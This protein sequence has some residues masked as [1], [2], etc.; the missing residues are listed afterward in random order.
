MTMGRSG[1]FTLTRS[2]AS[3][4]LIVGLND[5]VGRE[6]VSAMRQGS[7]MMIGDGRRG[8]LFSLR[9]SSDALSQLD[10]HCRMQAFRTAG[11]TA[12]PGSA[13]LPPDPF[14]GRYQRFTDEAT[15]TFPDPGDPFDV[16]RRYNDTDVPGFDL[17]SGLTDPL[18]AGIS[19]RQC[20]ALC[21]LTEDCTIYT[22]NGRDG[23]ICFL[24][25]GANGAT[26]YRGAVSGELTEA[27][28]RLPPPPTRG[29]GPMVDESVAW[30]PDDTPE[31][32]AARVRAAAAPLGR[33]CEAER[34][35][36]QQLA[37]RI[38]LDAGTGLGRVGQPIVF[39][40]RG[41]DLIE[42]IPVWVMAE[43]PAPVRFKGEGF[44]ALGPE[45]PT[46]FG[47]KAGR[48]QSR[49]MVA[50][51]AR[52]AGHAGKI[53]MMPLLAGPTP[54]RLSV[55]AYLRACQEEVVLKQV[56]RVVEVTPAPPRL[57]VGTP[58]SR[59]DFTHTINVP[60]FDRRI[61]LNET[62][63]RITAR[64]GTEIVE[65]AGEDL[66]LSSTLRFVAV[67]HDGERE[68]VDIVDGQT[69]ARAPAW[70][71][72]WAPGDSWFLTTTS[73]YGGMHVRSPFDNKVALDVGMTGPS[74]CG[75]F[76]VSDLPDRTVF[77]DIRIDLENAV[78]SIVG[79]EV[80]RSF[81]M[82]APNYQ[83][84]ATTESGLGPMQRGGRRDSTAMLDF[85]T[86]SSIGT[87][88][89]ISPS[90]RH[91]LR[92]I[93]RGIQ[94]GDRFIGEG[95]ERRTA[96]ISD[97]LAIRSGGRFEWSK[98]VANHAQSKQILSTEHF[99]R[100][101]MAFS[102]QTAP[103]L[104]LD[105]ETSSYLSAAVPIER[106]SAIR[107]ALA[108]DFRKFGIPLIWD[109]AEE[110]YATESCSHVDFS[111]FYVNQRQS[112][113]GIVLPAAISGAQKFE[114]E[115]EAPVWIIS[116]TCEFG[117]TFG[118]LG[119]VGTLLL[120][121]LRKAHPANVLDMIVYS[122]EQIAGTY[123]NDW[124]F[125]STP[126][127]GYLSGN[128]LTLFSSR[129][130]GIIVI[131]LDDKRPAF[132]K[133]NLPSGGLLQDAYLTE[134]YRHVVQVNS[135]G[136]L[137]VHRIS[138]GETVLHGRIVEDE[139]A[140]WTDDFHFDVT[141]EAAAAIDLR[142]P[143]LDGQFSLDRFA[144][145]R[146]VP[147]LA[148]MALA[149][150]VP[151]APAPPV[152][153]MLEAKIE[154]AGDK[155]RIS[156]ALDPRYPAEVIEVYQDGVLTDTIPASEAD[157]LLSIPRLQGARWAAVVARAADGT[158]SREV[159]ADLGPDARGRGRTA[160]LLVGVDVYEDPRLTDLNYAKVDVGTLMQTMMAPQVGAD[161]PEL[162]VDAGATPAAILSKLQ[163]T[164]SGLG[165]QDH[166][167][168]FF[169]GHGLTG[170]DGAFYFATAGTDPDDPAGTALVWSEV[171]E[172]LADTQA[173]ITILLDA[174][175]AGAA[176]S[177]VFASNDDAVAGLSAIPAN[178]T[179][180]AASK[181]RE[182]STESDAVGGGLFT[183]ALSEV[184]V[185]ER[186]THDTNGNGRIETTELWRGVRDRVRALS[187]GEQTPWLTR[188]RMVGDYALF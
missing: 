186:A 32:H 66:D 37:E 15:M 145:T 94:S 121:D 8:Y 129:V 38:T 18:L 126:F 71:T 43:T 108:V 48:G 4:A 156:T 11:G 135:D 65:R 89:S 166:G 90:R 72:A 64:D 92:N 57:V 176:N 62:R 63:F 130:A 110:E 60:K 5:P 74:C 112:N 182:V 163:D 117:G 61:E 172:I 73:P 111:E 102:E 139:I 24:K 104:N 77:G 87:I 21:Q 9:G 68:V 59:A 133:R 101:G 17:R 46:P 169:A 44:F 107:S 113:R 52:G 161:V 188:T 141:A 31:T 99:G 164:V 146:R 123:L 119:M 25:S 103:L 128:Y 178:V 35:D 158:A 134:D 185:T 137:H 78:L 82:Q 70:Q 148:S 183:A 88:S 170:P 160:A 56:D 138:D 177:G 136:G 124:Q 81:P 83:G 45:A 36:L 125:H 165:P 50:L 76:D 150:E 53:D 69:V 143:G 153:P 33:T 100:L 157:H 152:P 127:R 120:I 147:G 10:G 6:I 184:L 28:R 75:A 14:N 144:T 114:R 162:L 105:N 179:I 67:N 29:P 149:G 180:L 115:N 173:R 42:R 168:L 23:N 85:I 40:Y 96:T 34:A 142:F 27:V 181:G 79:H 122:S 116:Y 12:S 109:M 151:R 51:W 95:E 7:E 154:A 20:A 140:V 98:V 106:S 41:N 47:I 22:W 39:S 30:R 84:D 3:D 187:N 55:V 1:S 16:F 131:N 86:L 155:V 80:G 26:R 97:V 49:A 13:S 175:H 171:A 54:V 93:E 91:P 19:E 167:V 118:G 174:C 132:E 159:T 58:A 2:S